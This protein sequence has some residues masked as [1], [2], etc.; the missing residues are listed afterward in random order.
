MLR[1]VVRTELEEEKRTGN[2]SPL[3]E[4]L[5]HSDHEL[6]VLVQFLKTVTH[7]RM[8]PGWEGAGIQP[9]HAE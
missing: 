1:E 9:D 8:L 5:K 6:Q 3:W 2:G 4:S 7:Y